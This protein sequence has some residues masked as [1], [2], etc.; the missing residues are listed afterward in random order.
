MIGRPDGTN[1]L[2]GPNVYAADDM[3]VDC[4]VLSFN[5]KYVVTGSASGPPQV[6]DMETG[7][8]CKI[9]DGEELGC[10]DLHL[11]CNDELLVG[12]VVDDITA[13]GSTKMHRL[14]LWNFATGARLEM[15]SEIV[16]SASCV[17]NEGVHII[18]ARHTPSG[19]SILDRLVVAGFTNPDDDQAYFMVFDLA[20]HTTGIVQPNFVVFDA[21]PEATEIL[22]NEE[23]V[24][25][26]RKGELVVWNLLTGQPVRQIEISATLEGGNRANLPPHTG[27]IHAVTLSADKRYLVTGAQD[28]LVRV[29]SMPEERLLHTL[30]GHA[31]DV[32]LSICLFT[33]VYLPSPPSCCYACRTKGCL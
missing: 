25:G 7:E 16:C 15:P 19:P 12:Q 24:T 10:N 1:L 17:S 26:T 22:N 27:I 6:W 32:C 14:Q 18:A 20:A 28:R 23:A 9:M 33:F 11:A 4:C 13:A 29:W 31:D 3:K 2:T 5:S 30:E 8:P 21:K